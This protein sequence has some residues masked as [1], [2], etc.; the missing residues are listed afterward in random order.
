MKEMMTT[1]AISCLLLL[2]E[3]SEDLKPGP[4]NILIMSLIFNNNIIKIKNEIIEWNDI[5]TINSEGVFKMNYKFNKTT[6]R[7]KGIT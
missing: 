7:K 5:N 6:T 4:V 1:L 2:V 3:V